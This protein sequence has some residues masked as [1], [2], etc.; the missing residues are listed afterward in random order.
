M[1]KVPHQHW[2]VLAAFAQGREL[3]AHHVEAM[4]K[5]FAEFT[6]ANHFF[7]IAVRRGEDAHVHENCLG[8]ADTL[9][10]LLLEHAQQFH[11]GARREV[12][13]LVEEECALVRLLK[14][15][16]APLVGAGE[17]AA[18]VAEQFAFEK[19]FGDGGAIDGDEG[20]FGARA[21]LVDR[22]GNQFLARSRFALN[23]HRDGLGGDATDLFAHVL[24]RAAGPDERRAALNRSTGQSHRFTHEPAGIHGALKHAEE[25]RHLERLLQIIVSAK[26]GGFDGRLN[27]PVR[28]HQHHR[29]ARLGFVKPPH[30]IKAAQ[31]GQPQIGQHNIIIIFAGAAQ[32]VVAAMAHGDFEAVVLQH[33]A[34]VGGQTGVV[35]NEQNVSGFG[36]GLAIAAK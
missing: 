24:H 4:E 25:F 6:P 12:A 23:E 10:G 34:Q 8:P 7:Q 35:F 3:N 27:R 32:P 33:I 29:Q 11:L 20:R 13:D 19:I 28:R 21:V 17:R 2:N 26:F 14:T 36:H 15:T 9:K 31:S 30:K 1:E 18:F 22:A 5:V 16:D